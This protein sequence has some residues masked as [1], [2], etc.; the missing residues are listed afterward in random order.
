MFGGLARL[1]AEM[2]SQGARVFDSATQAWTPFLHFSGPEMSKTGVQPSSYHR[3][4]TLRPRELIIGF[5]GC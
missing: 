3:G 2:F 4:L 1:L 5:K